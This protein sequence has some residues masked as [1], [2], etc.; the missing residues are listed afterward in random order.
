[1]HFAAAIAEA[2]DTQPQA[3]P[4]KVA[5]R[6]LLVD[7]DAL[8]YYCAGN[9]D[10]SSGE[11]RR[12]LE[13]K[14]ES[15]MRAAGADRVLILVTGSASHKGHRYAISRVKQYQGKRSGNK[16]R[17]WQVMRELIEHDTRSIVTD[18]LE[19]DDLFH[20]NSVRLGFDNVAILTQDKDMRMVPGW[21]LNWE[22]HALVHVRPDTWAFEVDGKVFGRKWFWLQMLQ[23][24]TADN[25]PGLTRCLIGGKFKLCGE[26]TAA[27][28]LANA[29][30]EF[31]AADIVAKQYL[32]TYGEKSIADGVV[33]LLEQACLLWM[34]RS[35]RLFD[36][37]DAGGPLEGPR[38]PL[39]AE[40]RGVIRSRVV[41]V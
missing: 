1:M 6:M 8:A 16:P 7:G 11:A 26:V 32:A 36:C 14:I 33:A 28:L 37:M 25:V 12:N 18:T 20:V 31:A 30:S 9:D 3:R 21:H 19:A 24:D 40:A 41:D 10:T 29:D 27:K 35:D 22:S 13:T 2:S 39:L 34:R 38:V 15:A 17:N 5:G 4:D 23:G